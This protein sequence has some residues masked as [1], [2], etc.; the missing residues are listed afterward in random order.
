MAVPRNL[1]YVFLCVVIGAFLGMIY[2]V[3]FDENHQLFSNQ[4]YGGLDVRVHPLFKFLIAN[5]EEF[6]YV[7]EETLNSLTS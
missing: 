4:D 3:Y 7:P 5:V 1:V 6:L 2:M